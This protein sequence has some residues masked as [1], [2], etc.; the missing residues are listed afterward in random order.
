MSYKNK[1][2]TAGDD[3]KVVEF[4]LQNVAKAGDIVQSALIDGQE[5]FYGN[6]LKHI[7]RPLPITRVKMDWYYLIAA[8][9]H[10]FLVGT[11]L[12]HIGSKMALMH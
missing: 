10:L 4:I 11:N 5:Q 8:F 9:S 12:Q 6:H 1:C 2:E 3:Q 7:R